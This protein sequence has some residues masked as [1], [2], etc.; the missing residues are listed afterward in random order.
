MSQTTSYSQE[1]LLINDAEKALRINGPNHLGA[2]MKAFPVKAATDSDPL[3]AKS[4][5]QT[6]RYFY[7][8]AT[9]IACVICVAID[10]GAPQFGQWNA[11]F[12]QNWVL[13]LLFTV[14]G[15]SFALS[16]QALGGY[17]LRLS[18]YFFIGVLINL[19]AW[20]LTNRDWY[21]DIFGMVFQFAFVAGLIIYS[22]LLYPMKAILQT[23]H[24]RAIKTFTKDD[25]DFIFELPCAAEALSSPKSMA[26]TEPAAEPALATDTESCQEA[27]PTEQPHPSEESES[28][29]KAIAVIILMAVGIY[30]LMWAVVEPVV[31]AFLTPYAAKFFH[32]LSPGHSMRYWHIPS[33]PLKAGQMVNSFCQYTQC[34]LCS[35]L[36]ALVFPKL[37]N[38]TSIVGWLVFA[39]MF[40][41]RVYFHR[42]KEERIFHGFDIFFLSFVIAHYGLRH[43]AQVA[44]IVVRYWFVWL[45]MC[46]LI[47][48]PGT[49]Q[50]LDTMIPRDAITRLRVNSLDGFFILAWLTAGEYLFDDRIYTQDKLE[51]LN[52]WALAVFLLH[53]AIHITFQFPVN[54]SILIALIPICF[55]FTRKQ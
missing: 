44:A 34:S 39:H 35:I 13:Q 12:T 29:F 8:D 31:Q 17:V 25:P 47:W 7:L 33:D 28:L 1:S 45:I 9:R 6:R 3:I 21:H 18:A 37:H 27:S 55:I 49:D 24:K 30:V 20:K 2:N 5:S 26:A 43:R 36:I 11:V 42:D 22:L 38:R 40:L 4:K 32:W 14:S 23:N 46:G 15:V 53:K 52:W 51:F 54:W 41:N 10:H 50:R 16:R 19:T 48:N